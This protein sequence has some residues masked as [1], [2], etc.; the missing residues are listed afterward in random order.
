[1]RSRVISLRSCSVLSFVVGWALLCS[2]PVLHA[3]SFSCSK[4]NTLRERTVCARKQLSTMNSELAAVYK[5]QLAVLSPEAAAQV[6]NDHREWLRFL[7]RVCPTGVKSS[8]TVAACLQEHYIVRLRQMKPV[9]QRLDG[10]IFFARTQVVFTPGKPASK[11]NVRS[12]TDPGFGYGEFCWLQI[13]KP[14]PAQH[15]WNEAAYQAAV[16]AQAGAVNSGAASFTAGAESTG[17]LYGFAHLVAANRHLVDVSYTTESY[18]WGGAHPTT[19]EVSFLWWL[20][21]GRAV[22]VHDVFEPSSQWTTRLTVPALAA[23]RKQRAPEA[24]YSGE[25]LNK[26][27]MEGVAQ[28]ANWTLTAEGLTITFAQYQVGPYVSGMPSITLP[29]GP[30]Q[31]LLNT[32]LH[33]GELPRMLPSADPS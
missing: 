8:Q 25:E 20:E 6:R 29:W 7:D 11:G 33:P 21:K 30:L 18:N 16:N 4:A 1:M 19:E 13:D 12:L 26:G 31:P 5:G 14:T 23:L 32:E 9:S 24:L 28:L 15:A 27:L 2:L 3:A 22:T 17:S 10:M